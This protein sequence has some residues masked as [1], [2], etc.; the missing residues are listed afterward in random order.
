MN[1]DYLSGLFDEFRKNVVAEFKENSETHDSMIT[2]IN[3]VDAKINDF[4]IKMAEE[5][6]TIRTTAGIISAVI[7]AISGAGLTI[8]VSII[9]KHVK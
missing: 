3:S 4:K 9:L 1:L 2:K 6:A 5:I 8:F 7:G